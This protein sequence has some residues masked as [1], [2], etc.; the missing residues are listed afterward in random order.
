MKFIFTLI[1]AMLLSSNSFANSPSSNTEINP[2][3]IRL[4]NSSLNP[5]TLT[6]LNVESE[7][8]DNLAT[9]TY[10]L[11]FFNPNAYI[12]FVFLVIIDND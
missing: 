6:E 2:P 4:S 8:I 5:I 1:F 11:V 7:V 10:E 3:I 12:F 9:S